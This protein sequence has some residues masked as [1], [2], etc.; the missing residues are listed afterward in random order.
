TPAPASRPAAHP[1]AGA[2]A[3]RS[4]GS[5]PVQ[6]P[7]PIPVQTPAPTPVQTVKKL[8]YRQRKRLEELE[9]EIQALE[10]E[11]FRLESLLSDPERPLSQITEASVRMGEILVRLELDWEELLGLED[12]RKS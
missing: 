4:G 8:T 11:K 10:E 3:S 7:A 2:A 9:A 12:Q 6:T 1:G 5:I